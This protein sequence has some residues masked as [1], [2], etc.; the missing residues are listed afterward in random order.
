[1]KYYYKEHLDDYRKVKEEGKVARGEIYG[2]PGFDNFAARPF[3]EAVLPTLHFKSFPPDALEYGC[4]TGPGACYLAQRGFR[5]DASDLI[6]T[7]IE[8]ARQEAK[9]RN[10]DI[11]YEVMDI[12]NLPVEGKRYDLIVDSYCL[13]G[14]VFEEDR[15]KVFSAVRA[16][17]KPD[18]YYLV[19]T[20]FFNPSGYE[21]DSVVIDSVSNIVYHIYQETQLI[22]IKTHIVYRLLDA[23]PDNYE[24]ALKIN[25]VWYLPVRRHYTQEL[26]ETEIKN[27]GFK[28]LPFEF[29]E[30]GHLI[31]IR[32]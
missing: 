20:A 9:K 14:I 12:C 3:L 5:V 28:V 11:R 29:P 24:D 30:G 18:G 8:I 7:A 2:V 1:M 25:G 16:R 26:L 6:P 10:L 23:D 21:P 19:N 13:Q 4:G 22:D 15:R 17:L 31:G 32:N 27:A